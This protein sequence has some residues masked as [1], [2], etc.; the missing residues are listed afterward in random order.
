MHRL[1]RADIAGDI[2]HENRD[3]L[4]N[5]RSNLRPASRGQQNAN[6]GIR[7]DNSSGFI[8]VRPRNNRWQARISPEG[9]EAHVG[10]FD[11]P[12]DA[13]RARDAAAVEHY[14]EFAVLNFPTNRE[15]AGV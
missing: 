10:Y 6:Q 12:E 1:I 7:R 14:G 4:D 2:D 13:A 11:S 5:R 15:Q 8:G 3:S 9:K